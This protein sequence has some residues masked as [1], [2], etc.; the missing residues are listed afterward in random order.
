MGSGFRVQVDGF[1]VVVAASLQNIYLRRSRH[2]HFGFLIQAKIS[3]GIKGQYAPEANH[4]PANLSYFLLAFCFKSCYHT[5][6]YVQ[7]KMGRSWEISH[8]EPPG[9]ERRQEGNSGSPRS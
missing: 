5:N 6:V 2:H 1:K 8:R 7:A 9:L 4:E 3:N